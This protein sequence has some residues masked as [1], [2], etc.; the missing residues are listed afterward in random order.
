MCIGIIR[1]YAYLY[2][3]RP[4]LGALTR[5]HVR[6]CVIFVKFIHMSDNFQ[7]LQLFTEQFLDFL[8]VADWILTDLYAYA[9]R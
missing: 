1:I 3:S 6:I 2:L 5:V 4:C 7:F 9:S 8:K